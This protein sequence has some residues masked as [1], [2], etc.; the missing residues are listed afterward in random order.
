M[1][2]LDGPADGPTGWMVGVAWM[3]RRYQPDDH[4]ELRPAEQA[5]PLA[6]SWV[7]MLYAL[8]A[9]ELEL[10]APP[11]PLTMIPPLPPDSEGEGSLN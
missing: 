11:P 7:P 8:M 3:S 6:H 2:D 1:H 9:E 4:V 5:R 10:P